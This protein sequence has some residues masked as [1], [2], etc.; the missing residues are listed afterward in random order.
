MGAA[1]LRTPLPVHPLQSRPSGQASASARQRSALLWRSWV[2]AFNLKTS[3]T[4]YK[5]VFCKMEQ[6]PLGPPRLPPP[7]HYS[8]SLLLVVFSH[9]KLS[10][11]CAGE[12][13][14]GR[15]RSP[16]NLRHSGQTRM[17]VQ[18]RATRAASC[19]S[20]CARGSGS[21]PLHSFPLLSVVVLRARRS[22]GI[23]GRVRIIPPRLRRGWKLSLQRMMLRSS[24]TISWH[25]DTWK[26]DPRDAAHFSASR[27]LWIPMPKRCGLRFRFGRWILMP[28]LRPQCLLQP[29]RHHLLSET[30]LILDSG[31]PEQCATQTYWRP[32]SSDVPHFR[33][34]TC[35]LCCTADPFNS[36]RASLWPRL[37]WDAGVP[38]MSVRFTP[39][40]V[41][42]EL[43]CT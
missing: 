13:G 40:H 29:K 16:W 41:H 7:Q 5:S 17:C 28:A 2:T 11:L 12:P 32:K 35:M 1:H 15:A 18:P 19:A 14:A 37:Q 4:L 31:F 21:P 22:S 38:E 39:S 20:L 8:G 26:A 23:A 6:D 36:P 34:G 10:S 24:V 33:K 30:L 43:L 9:S 25:T 27:P 3:L 42:S